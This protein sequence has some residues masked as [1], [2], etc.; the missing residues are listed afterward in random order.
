[1]LDTQDEFDWTGFPNLK[2][3]PN[4]DVL[5]QLEKKIKHA[6]KIEGTNIFI[7]RL[8]SI[9]MRY[10]DCF[11][12]ELGRDPPVDVPPLAVKIKDGCEP[13]KCK[14]RRY[15]IDH[16]KF[17]RRH[18]DSLVSADLV[19]LNEQSSWCSPPLIVPKLGVQDP[20]MIIDLRKVNAITNRQI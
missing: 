1:M 9:F 12:T 13:I 10:K 3:Q 16:Q 14:N 7:T 8:C 17:M 2:D 15:S 6:A 19:Y 4:D 20:R 5:N 18:V 11:R